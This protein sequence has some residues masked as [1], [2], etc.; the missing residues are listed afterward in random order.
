MAGH[1]V[2]RTEIRDT[3]ALVTHIWGI[4][5][6]VLLK[7]ILMSFGALAS[8]WPVTLKQ[9]LVERNAVKCR[10]RGY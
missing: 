1:R 2:A 10:T 8:K 6:L 4:F 3:G 9:L 5:D 7:V